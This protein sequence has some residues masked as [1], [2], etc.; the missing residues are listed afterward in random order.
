[1]L[2]KGRVG[3]KRPSGISTGVKSAPRR[4]SGQGTPES[5]W[6]RVAA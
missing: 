3:L 5:R 6:P 1:V 4:R 2:A